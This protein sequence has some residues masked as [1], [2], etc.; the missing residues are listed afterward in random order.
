MR[1]EISAAVARAMA[2]QPLKAAGIYGFWGQS[3]L[4]RLGPHFGPHKATN[5]KK[6]LGFR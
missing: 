5:K 3:T 1:S 2:N 4:G 6:G